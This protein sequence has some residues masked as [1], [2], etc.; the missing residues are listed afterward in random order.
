MVIVPLQYLPSP[1]QSPETVQAVGKLSYNQLV[2]KIITFKHSAD[3]S[4][5]SEG[6]MAEQ[7]LE[8][9]ATQLSYHGLCELGA[10]AKEGELSVFFRNNHFSAMIK[11]KVPHPPT[12]RG[13]GGGNRVTPE[14]TGEEKERLTMQPPKSYSVR[15]Q[16]SSRAATGKPAGAQPDYRG[17]W[18]AMSRKHPDRPNPPSPP[19]DARPIVRRPL[20]APD[21]M[22]AMALQQHRGKQHSG[23]P[24]SDLDLA[25][26]L[27]EEEYQ[28]QQ[29]P[30]PQPSSQQSP[31]DVTAMM[32]EWDRDE[33]QRINLSEFLGGLSDLACMIAHGSWR[34]GQ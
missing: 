16:R 26:Q 5:V 32:L 20:E 10:T 4:V 33:D 13:G 21:Y 1:V 15:G 25:K 9:T 2:E 8:S 12:A 19:G 29:Q 6:L 22:V 3:S 27:Q 7:F 17:R 14:V 23:T 34:H 28:Q 24:L 30:P 11:H 31:Q 18:C